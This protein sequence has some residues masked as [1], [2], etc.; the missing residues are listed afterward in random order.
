MSSTNMIKLIGLMLIVAA[1]NILVFSPGLIGVQI[2]TSALSTATGVTLL[3]ASGGVLVIGIYHLLFKKPVI[4]P[5]KQI[6]TYDEYIEHLSRYRHA[7]GIES[8]ISLAL[9]QMERMQK[10]KRTL[11][12][13]LQQRFEETEMSYKKFASVTQEVEH[14]FYQNIRSIL[15]ILHVYDESEFER[16]FQKKSSG[17]S[18]ELVQK[19]A[20]VY[21]DYLS[22]ITSSI[23]NNE[24][25]L[26]R[27]DQ[28]LLEISSLDHIEPGEIEQL[29]CV[30][31][32]DS[33]I[34]QTKY[35]KQ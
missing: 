1:V 26:L 30:Q 33:L 32:L 6:K 15:N 34:R 18:N 23:S 5:V 14:L 7:K 17:F 20:S 31:E 28:L 4:I 11:I 2:G 35:Y 29:S 16:V 9:E 27:L 8:D 24:E 10:R 25:I 22:T 3:F 19:K 12:E 13:V 21:Q